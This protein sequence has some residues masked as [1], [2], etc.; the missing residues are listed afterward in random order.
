MASGR[1]GCEDTITSGSERKQVPREEEGPKEAGKRLQRR[2]KEGSRKKK[3]DA[4]AQRPGLFSSSVVV[5]VG[6]CCCV[7]MFKSAY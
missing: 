5:V 1:G 7:N 4:D 3:M 6:C 2:D